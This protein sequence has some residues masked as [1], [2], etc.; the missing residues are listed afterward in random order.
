MSYAYPKFFYD[1][2]CHISSFL[3]SYPKVAY[4]RRIHTSVI[5]FME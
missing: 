3:P 2:S 1:G 5:A 4:M